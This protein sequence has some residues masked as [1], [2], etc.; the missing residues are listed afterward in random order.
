MQLAQPPHPAAMAAAV[1]HHHHLL[2][3]HLLSPPPRRQPRLFFSPPPPPT[4]LRSSLRA[5]ACLL[6]AAESEWE[7]KDHDEGAE[8][9][10]VTFYKFVPVEDPR[11]EV[12]RHLHFLQVLPVFNT[13]RSISI[14]AVHFFLEYLSPSFCK[15]YYINSSH[16]M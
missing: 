13:T 7:G 5:P 3:L 2:L 16:V 11:A 10:V 12:A 6:A 15:T 9:V 14:V 4:R 1:H 8:F